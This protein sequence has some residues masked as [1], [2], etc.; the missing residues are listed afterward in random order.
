MSMTCEKCG[1]TILD[2]SIGGARRGTCNCKEP[3][4]VETIDLT[5]V[6]ADELAK[7]PSRG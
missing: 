1:G 5:R 7:E 6:L 2:P 4:P 3:K